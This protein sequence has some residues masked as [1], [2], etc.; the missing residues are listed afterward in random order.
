MPL[1]RARLV[2]CI[3]GSGGVREMALKRSSTS[4]DGQASTD[5]NRV[6]A[7]PDAHPP[8]LLPPPPPRVWL[9]C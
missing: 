4:I 2:C 7:T 5:E 3:R 8:A 6:A 9:I 1:F